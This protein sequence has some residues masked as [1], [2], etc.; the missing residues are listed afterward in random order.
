MPQISILNLFF[1][2]L[3]FSLPLFILFHIFCLYIHAAGLRTKSV[4]VLVVSRA[5]FSSFKLAY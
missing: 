2:F 4:A 3:H 5:A 1:F